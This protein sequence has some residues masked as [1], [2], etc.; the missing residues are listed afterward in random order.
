MQTAKRFV[1]RLTRQTLALVLA[2]GR[3]SRLHDLTKWR[4]KPAV[5]FGGKFR[6]IDFPLS[7]CINS[8]IGQVGVI[9]QY[10]SHSLI[11]HIQRGWGF[12]RGE[13]DE[14]VE[15]LPA[16]QRIETS[17]YE[18]TADAVLQNL[19]II[20]SHMP[21]YVLILAGD[22]I[23]KMD[24]G[25]M[26]AA[27]VENDADITVG[28]IEVPID[29]ASAFGVMS[30]NDEMKIT[31]FVEKPAHPKAMPGQPDKALA[32]MGIYVFSTQ[33]LFDELM[34]DQQMD[35]DSSH[36]FGKDIIP[37]VIKR[38]RVVAFPFRNPVQ[39][40]PAYWRDVGTIDALWQANLEL[41]SIS[42]ELN[43]YDSH[44]PIWTY[45]EQLPP[46]K[47]VF[48]DD[49]R[50]GMAVDSMVAG[51][52]I[53]SGALV[54]HSLLFSQVM[55]HSFSEISNSVIYPDVEIGR[56][57]HIRNALIDR[58]CRIP[59]GTRIGFDAV[60]DR[61]RFYVSPKGVVLITPEMLGQDYPHGL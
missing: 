44:W 47:F 19:D 60:E 5:P 59:E 10:K 16:Q 15:L 35:G 7:N 4:A 1:S 54:K 17:W 45:Q 41:I 13:L 43:L 21:E 11:R 32:S 58:G 37:S 52:C 22:H 61:K 46:A 14:F 50:R 34:R 40:K 31:E 25:T 30:V 12:L 24:Y 38:L 48:D 9:T 55:V 20:R 6:I 8:G 56:H 23:Y 29:E 53:V 42:P 28:C 39:N 36:D 57:C 2:G 33:V 26:L 49:N 51:G 18:G 27:H 3:G